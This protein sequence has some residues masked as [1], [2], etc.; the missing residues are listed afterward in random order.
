MTRKDCFC[1]LEGCGRKAEEAVERIYD[2][3]TQG[4]IG[5]SLCLL[6][7]Y[8]CSATH[9]TAFALKFQSGFLKILAI[10][11]L[12]GQAEKDGLRYLD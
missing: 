7:A 11:L 10:A 9:A 8:F 1:F 2:V 5:S 4:P 12:A 3:I 6:T